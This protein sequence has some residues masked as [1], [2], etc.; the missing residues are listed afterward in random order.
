MRRRQFIT[1]AGAAVLWPRGARSQAA[2]MPVVGILLLGNPDPAIF[3]KGF[4]EAL[5]EAGYVEGR[6]VR[7]EIRSAEGKTALLS[8]LAAELVRLKVD[9]IVTSLTPTALAAK[10]ATSDIPIVMAAAGDPVQTGLV[11]SLT[12]PGG[13]VTG[14]SAA[15]AKIAGKSLELVREVLPSARRLAVLA[16]QSDPFSGPFVEQVSESARALNF[17]VEPVLVALETPLDAIVEGFSRSRIDALI[18]QG[19]M[20]RKDLF[21]LAIKYRLPSFSSNNQ[22]ARAGGLAT[23]SASGSEIQRAAV[24]YV[25]KIL[26]G[27]KPADLPVALPTRFELVINLRT[28]KAIGLPL[29]PTLLARADEIIE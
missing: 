2:K 16:V 23:Y 17:E 3:V 6:N 26:K 5:A 27:R 9:V 15:S 4:R 7:L 14:V 29:G 22:I 24:D 10:Q 18:V 12:R 13:N 25:D 8:E 21:D 19:G 11:A 20:L 28:A 1:L